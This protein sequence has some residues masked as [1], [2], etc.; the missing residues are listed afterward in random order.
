MGSPR[1]FVESL[2]A[3]GTDAD[4]V[5]FYRDVAP[6]TLAYLKSKGARLIRFHLLRPW[7]GPVHTR[8]FVLFA[9][10]AAAH[11]QRYRWIM[12]SDLRDVLIQSDPAAELDDGRVQF[13][14]ENGRHTISENPYA[15]RWMHLFIPRQLHAEYG[16]CRPA[17][18][19][20]IL[21]GGSEMAVYLTALARRIGSISLRH[22]FRVGA[23]TALHNLIAHITRDVPGVLVENNRRVATMGLEPDGTYHIDTAGLIAC[24]DGH[25]PSICHQYD[26]MPD[27]FMQSRFASPS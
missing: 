16:R 18:C 12:T 13:F 7:H 25:V 21:G 2:L 9:R 23:D 26:R 20:V 3:S 1:V 6:E 5:V 11:F 27:L 14:L 15:A 4:L 22:R 17:C 24:V 19:G 10:Y 8:R